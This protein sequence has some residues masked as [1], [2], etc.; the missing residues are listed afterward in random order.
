MEKLNVSR[1]ILLATCLTLGATACAETSVASQPKQ[2]KQE[3]VQENAKNNHWTVGCTAEAADC[4][5][6]N[7][8][9]IESEYQNAD[10]V[11]VEFTNSVG[12][13]CTQVYTQQFYT[14]ETA[15]SVS[16]SCTPPLSV[17]K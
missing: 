12:E 8:M 5:V 7:Q 17:V 4:K 6:T 1:K 15:P 2:T 14:Q 10:I 9:R 16:I 13:H 11:T 3:K